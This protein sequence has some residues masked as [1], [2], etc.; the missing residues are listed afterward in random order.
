MIPDDAIARIVHIAE[1]HSARSDRPG[2][3]LPLRDLV[4]QSEYRELRPHLTAAR[5]EEYLRAHPDN[6][7]RW[8][9]WSEDKRTRG[10][11]GVGPGNGQ[12]YI[13]RYEDEDGRPYR[14]PADPFPDGP[15]AVAEYI[16]RELDFWV[17]VSDQSAKDRFRRRTT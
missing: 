14:K 12:W 11:W 17:Q 3:G 10:G 2:S 15:S 1:L 4:R 16:L 9:H 8:V 7:E 6:V 5:L 13:G